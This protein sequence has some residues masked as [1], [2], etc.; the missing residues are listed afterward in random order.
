[1][2][3]SGTAHLVSSGYRALQKSMPLSGLLLYQAEVQLCAVR[4]TE[5]ATLDPDVPA[6]QPARGTG[7]PCTKGLAIQRRG[8]FPNITMATTTTAHHAAVFRGRHTAGRREDDYVI[9]IGAY[10]SFFRFECL[11][12][13]P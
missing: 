3:M 13:T 8:D 11:Q 4:S 5:P 1:M 2:C 9:S 7:D 10:T 12:K 6:A